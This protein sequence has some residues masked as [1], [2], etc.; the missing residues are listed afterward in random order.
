MQ[1]P[2]PTAILTE[3]QRADAVLSLAA[4]SSLRGI[5]ANCGCTLPQLQQEM[6]Q[7]PQ[8]G[9]QMEHAKE[10]IA[11]RAFLSIVRAAATEASAAKWLQKHLPEA[12]PLID[13]VLN[14]LFPRALTTN[15]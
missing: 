5:A 3:K 4:G 12:A 8:F 11:A 14:S 7:N 9:W 10:I 15:H 2:H 13:F 1:T 6:Q